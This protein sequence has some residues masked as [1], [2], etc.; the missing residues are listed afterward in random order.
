MSIPFC[1][2]G[3]RESLVRV[4]SDHSGRSP[5]NTNQAILSDWKKLPT[6]VVRLP[7]P[8]PASH[9]RVLPD[10]TAFDPLPPWMRGPRASEDWTRRPTRESQLID[11]GWGY[12]KL[13]PRSVQ[14]DAGGFQPFGP[15]GNQPK[16]G[17]GLTRGI[18]GLANLGQPRKPDDWGVLRAWAWAWGASRARTRTWRRVDTILQRISQST[19]CTAGGFH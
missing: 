3:K 5:R 7:S 13:N 12:A 2:L 10:P 6:A 8:W 15:G 18:I 9:L 17:A 11:A 4:R 19:C 14:D 16:R 1:V